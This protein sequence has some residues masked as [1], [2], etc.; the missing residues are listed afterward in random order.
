MNVCLECK[1]VV[2]IDLKGPSVTI[3]RNIHV[4]ISFLLATCDHFVTWDEK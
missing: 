1:T 2:Y 3:G 4:F